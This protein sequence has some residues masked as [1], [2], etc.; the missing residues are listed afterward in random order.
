MGRVGRIDPVARKTLGDKESLEL[1]AQGQGRSYPRQ[2]LGRLGNRRLRL[3]NRGG[4]GPIF[5]AAVQAIAF[6]EA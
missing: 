4:L 3:P 2:G 1:F 5:V 6:P